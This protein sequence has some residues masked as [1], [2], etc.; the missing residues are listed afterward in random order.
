VENFIKT[1]NPSIACLKG[2]AELNA[3]IAKLG[4]IDEKKI[5]AYILSH[6][7]AGRTDVCTI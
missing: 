1:L 6:F 4:P 3:I 2:N 5:L 7:I